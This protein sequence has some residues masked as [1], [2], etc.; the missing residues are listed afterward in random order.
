ML[1]LQIQQAGLKVIEV[2]YWDADFL[3]V[4]MS[5]R[6][7]EHVQLTLVIWTLVISKRKSG[8]SFNIEI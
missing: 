8:P 4:V 2:L 3:C 1:F 7:T 6:L 5:S